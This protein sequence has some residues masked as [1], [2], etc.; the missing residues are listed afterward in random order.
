[1]NRKPTSNNGKVVDSTSIHKLQIYTD[2]KDVPLHNTINNDHKH[3]NII[4]TTL[5][6]NTSG[7]TTRKVKKKPKCEYYVPTFHVQALAQTGSH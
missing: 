5:P 2:Y 6:K 3:Y 7:I 1:M 4:M